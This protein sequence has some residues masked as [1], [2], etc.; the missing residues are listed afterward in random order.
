[1]H[2]TL[3]LGDGRARPSGRDGRA[4]TGGRP[5]TGTRPCGVV[6]RPACGTPRSGATGGREARRRGVA[7]RRRRAPTSTAGLEAGCRPVRHRHDRLGRRPADRRA[8]SC[9]STARPPWP[10]RTSASAS[11]CSVGSW[12]RPWRSSGRS[13]RS[14]RTSSSGIGAAKRDRPSGTAG[15]LARAD[16]RRPPAPRHRRRPRGRIGPGRLVARDAPGRLRCRRRD[17]SSCA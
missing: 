17:A 12:R 11:C 9:A 10:R 5:G 8:R 14:I 3:I 15:D 16:R 1:M 7:R 4:R 6:G 13:T 2:T